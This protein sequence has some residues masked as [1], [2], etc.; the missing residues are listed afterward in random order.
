M[1][2]PPVEGLCAFSK[3]LRW[4]G[5]EDYADEGLS[6]IVGGQDGQ[7]L[8]AL[9]A[10]LDAAVLMANEPPLTR[11]KERFLETLRDLDQHA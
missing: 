8:E 3:R 10:A 9:A 4:I 11:L 6:A 2:G 7:V 5:R 1:Y